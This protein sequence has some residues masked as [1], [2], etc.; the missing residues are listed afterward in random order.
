MISM[1]FMG[2]IIESAGFKLASR[3]CTPH[4]VIGCFREA[5]LNPVPA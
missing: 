5:L 2:W 3:H 1:R 4:V